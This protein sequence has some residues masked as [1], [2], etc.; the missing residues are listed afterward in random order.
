MNRQHYS[1][2]QHSSVYQTV[3]IFQTNVER[4]YKGT[5]LEYNANLMYYKKTCALFTPIQLNNAA[6]T[7]TK[8]HR[9]EKCTQFDINCTKNGT[10]KTNQVHA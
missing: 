5:T 1:A 8:Y 2:E 10:E 7:H 6:H 9:K 3:C 4:K